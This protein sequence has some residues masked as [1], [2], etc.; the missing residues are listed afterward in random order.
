[1]FIGINN[2]QVVD[3]DLKKN[4]GILFQSGQFKKSQLKARNEESRAVLV[5][6][7]FS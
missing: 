2:K 7:D 3:L 4:V 1:M 6:T 5:D